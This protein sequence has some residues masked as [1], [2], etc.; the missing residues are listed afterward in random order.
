MADYIPAPDDAFNS[1]QVNFVT[2][3]NAN[4][5]ALGLVA[6]DMTPITAAQTAWATGFPAHVAAVANAVAARANKDAARTIYEAAIRPLVR[7]LQASPS[8]SDAERGALGI[9]IPDAGGGG[10]VPAPTTR[11]LIT[12]DC[13]QRLRHVIGFMDETT[14]TTKAKPAG[15]VGAEVWVKVLPVSEPPPTDPAV[16][17]FIALDTR[18]P[19]TL[20]FPGTDGGKN[21]HYIL[22]WANSTGQRG[23]WSETVSATIGM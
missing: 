22:R 19:Y 17:T 6:A 2:Y 18:T 8:V 7:R 21:A 10:P 16:F 5:A 1:W 20:D 12:V 11:P 3:A 14:P 15:V 4:L 23:P 13:S 9:T